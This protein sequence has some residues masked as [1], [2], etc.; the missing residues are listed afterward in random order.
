[1][2]VVV[3]VVV[4]IVCLPTWSLVATHGSETIFTYSSK[5]SLIILAGQARTAFVVLNMLPAGESKDFGP[6]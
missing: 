3:S 4:A 6:W 2:I 1:M 5:N